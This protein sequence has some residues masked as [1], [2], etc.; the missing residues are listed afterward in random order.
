M[1]EEGADEGGDADCPSSAPAVAK[2]AKAANAS[3]ASTATLHRAEQRLLAAAVH[4]S[5]EPPN[6]PPKLARGKVLVVSV[7]F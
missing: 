6:A 3:G 1:D 7:P 5:L 4:A 2:V